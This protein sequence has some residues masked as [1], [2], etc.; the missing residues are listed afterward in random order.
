MTRRQRGLYTRA[1]NDIRKF[2][3]VNR[4]IMPKIVVV[5]KSEQPNWCGWYFWGGDTIY[6]AVNTCYTPGQYW[7]YPRYFTD[8]S[9]YGVVCHEFGH[10]VHCKSGL[11]NKRP[12]FTGEDNVSQ[13]EI[14]T[15]EKIAEALRLFIG[16]PDLLH[17]TNPK[18]YDF[19]TS[20]LGLGP[21][22]T[23]SWRARLGKNVPAKY[24][25]SCNKR[26]IKAQR[27]RARV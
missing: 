15:L 2:C 11:D 4:L 1:V 23:Q 16:N 25:A 24:I 18:R 5:D 27:K 17:K 8:Q 10:Y 9:V 13:F 14:N 22:T 3:V 7:H 21:A 19:I 20:V 6:I 12:R 26:I